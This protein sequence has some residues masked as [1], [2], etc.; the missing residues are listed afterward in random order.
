MA[1]EDVISEICNVIQFS[2]SGQ[3]KKWMLFNHRDIALIV[4][5]TL[6]HSG[7]I[8]VVKLWW[9]MWLEMYRTFFIISYRNKYIT[10]IIDE[11]YENGSVK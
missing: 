10:R 11:T 4:L 5:V 6:V 9:S 7:P 8:V 2:L 3:V 1:V